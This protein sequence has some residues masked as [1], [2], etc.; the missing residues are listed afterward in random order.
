[1]IRTEAE[2]TPTIL[3][4]IYETRSQQNKALLQFHGIFIN[5]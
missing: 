4:L 2:I 3:C 1:M 5:E